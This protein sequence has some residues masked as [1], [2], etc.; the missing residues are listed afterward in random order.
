MVLIVYFVA[1]NNNDCVKESFFEYLI[2]IV[3]IGFRLRGTGVS[4]GYV[5]FKR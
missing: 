4:L 3:F 1:F 5:R 2:S